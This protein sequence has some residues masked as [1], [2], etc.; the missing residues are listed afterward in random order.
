[1]KVLTINRE[2][3]VLLLIIILL[4]FIVVIYIYFVILLDWEQPNFA[5]GTKIHR[6]SEKIT[7]EQVMALW[8]YNFKMHFKVEGKILNAYPQNVAF[9]INEIDAC[10][11]PPLVLALVV[12]AFKHWKNR[13][14]IRNTWG[15]TTLQKKTGIKT[16]FMVG[17]TKDSSE[18]SSV[19]QESSTFHDIV[20]ANFIDSY[21]NL[22]YKT[23]AILNWTATYCSQVPLL[24][25]IDDDVMPN[26]MALSDFL[27]HYLSTNPHPSSI[28]G[29]VRCCDP[30]LRTGKWAVSEELYPSK[31]YPSYVAG[32]SYLVPT[33]VIPALLQAIMR[34]RYEYEIIH[35][36]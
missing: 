17:Q 25:K 15:H 26:P 27:T 13:H 22:T 14:F 35:F 7:W 31:M 12:T 9:P 4:L 30:V 18:Q 1:M 20:Q 28:M 36:L 19:E 11:K 3:S 2:I 29:K 6:Q 34:T 21:D 24:L 10:E 23:I 16:I 32:P 33:T 5:Y 8:D